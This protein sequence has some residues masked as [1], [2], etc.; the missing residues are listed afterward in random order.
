MCSFFHDRR[1]LRVGPC[2]GLLRPMDTPD[3]ARRRRPAHLRRR[4][5]FLQ[6]A[7]FATLGVLGRPLAAIASTAT[8]AIEGFYGVLLKV[9]KAGK[10]TP[11]RQRYDVLAP[12][13]DQ[14]FDLDTIL[15]ASVGPRW[16]ALPADQQ[17]ALKEAFRRYTISTYVYN[18]DDFS[19]QRFEIQPGL[20]AA[21]AEEVVKTRIVP[22]SGEAHVLDYVMRQTGQT[23]RVVDVL[24]DGSISR[25]AVQ[26]SEMRSLIAQGG[27]PAL[28]NRL[29]Q[30][31]ADLSGGQLP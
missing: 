28:L 24:A 6:L 31:T 13:I 23:W 12:A 27:A 8:A 4:R 25:V 26:R 21:G 3:F 7:A 10:S 9:M 30:K 5:T 15:A 16:T 19:G 1:G 11:F 29:Q 2:C 22:A 20:T 17:Q 14:T 18:F